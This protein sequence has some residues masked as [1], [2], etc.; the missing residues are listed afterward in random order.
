MEADTEYTVETADGN[1]II[2][3]YDDFHQII[4]DTLND[5]CKDEVKFSVL[6]DE[7]WPV[8]DVLSFNESQYDAYK[9]ALT[10]EFAVVQGP[11]GTGKTYL[12]IKVAKTLFEN[13]QEVKGCLM[14]VICYTNHALDQFLEALLQITDSIVRIGGQSRNEAMDKINLNK[15]RRS[16]SIHSAAGHAFF[17]QKMTLKESISEF[18]RSL[19]RLDVL[20]NGVV[21][22]QSLVDDV[23]EVKLLRD[24]YKGA[25]KVGQDPLFYWLFENNQQFYNDID[26]LFED[27][28]DENDFS[29]LEKENRKRTGVLLDDHENND[30]GTIA[31]RKEIASFS[32]DA[33]TVQ[34]KQLVA[35]LKT[36]GNQHLQTNIVAQLQHLHSYKTM[37]NVSCF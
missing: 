1:E 23:N 16:I 30:A 27:G 21:R 11:P 36:T 22:S 25:L 7:T 32:V 19:V 9:L 33:A 3:E 31:Y 5:E 28:T 8:K 18:Q 12:G 10:H 20:L 17:D 29:N 2:P 4:A 35:Q 37:F 26:Y 34:I 13:L 15:L 14:L 6:Q 24:Y